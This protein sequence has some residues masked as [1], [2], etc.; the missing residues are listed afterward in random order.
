MADLSLIA[1]AIISEPLETFAIVLAESVNGD[2]EMMLA[3]GLVIVTVGATLETV[4][5]TVDIPVFP[6]SSMAITV[7]A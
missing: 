5:L 2:L 3:E 1:T 6:E 7:R 4:K